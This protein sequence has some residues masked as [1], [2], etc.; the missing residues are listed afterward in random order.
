MTTPRR[1]PLSAMTQGKRDD[2]PVR[3][4]PQLRVDRRL[5]EQA[6]CKLQS[7]A[8]PYVLFLL[9]SCGVYAVPQQADGE[10]RR[11]A[12]EVQSTVAEVLSDP[13]YRHLVRNDPDAADN[14]A[15]PDWLQRFLRWLFGA[16]RQDSGA[17]EPMLSLGSLLFYVAMVV[18]AILLVV[19]VIGIVQRGDKPHTESLPTVDDEALTPSQPPGDVPTNEYERRALA[20]AEAGD[21]RSALRELVLGSMSWTERAGLVRYRRGLSN[22]DYLRA[23]WRR[24]P[25]RDSLQQIIVE[26]E[27]VFY[28]RRPANSTT[29]A[30]CL[31]EFRKSFM[32]E[33][34]D[35][36]LAG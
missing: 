11:D 34:S 10:E 28:G 21:F 5:L 7:F 30:A 9:I 15:L 23:V 24:V 27:R 36:H 19:L 32:H 1:N 8:R 31:G 17:S 16:D 18:L 13:E 22:R 4:L 6:V 14:P 3:Q 29:F 35:A 20:A 33:E 26:F 12:A 25:Q 2:A